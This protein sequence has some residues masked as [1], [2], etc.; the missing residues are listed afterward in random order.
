MCP[1]PSG[2]RPGIMVRWSST[3]RRSRRRSSPWRRCGAAR[4]SVP[5]PWPHRHRPDHDDR[6]RRRRRHP[7]IPSVDDDARRRRRRRRRAPPRHHVEPRPRRRRHSAGA[8]AWAAFDEALSGRLIGSGDFAAAVAVAVHGEI[9]HSGEFGYRVP[10]PAAPDRRDPPASTDGAADV[11]HRDATTTI[12]A[13]SEPEPIEAGDRFR[14]ASISKVITAIVVLQLV[15]AGQLGLDDPV[16]ERLA[17]H[18]G[19]TITI[20]RLPPSRSASC[21]PT[22]GPAGYNN[23]FFGGG[24]D[25]ARRRR[26]RDCRVSHRAPGDL[27]LLELQLLPARS[28]RRAG[29]RPTIRGRRHRP[30]ARAAGHQGMRLAG[31]FD[32]DPAQ[33]VHPSA[34]LRNYMEVLGAAGS[35]VATPSDIVTSWTR[36]TRRR[37]AG[38]RC[39]RRCSS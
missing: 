5:R 36:S 7:T 16:G 19:V 10:P 34:P 15:E 4:R 33:V 18:V 28:A 39:R 14:I 8:P 13:P 3:A 26:S 2:G 20:R 11:D 37:R 21:S 38:T 9:V 23:T 32:D 30:P 29:R 1:G 27:P 17:A 22:R 35:W 31:T 12:A 25:R 6:D 24:A